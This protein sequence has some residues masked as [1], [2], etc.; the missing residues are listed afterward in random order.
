MQELRFRNLAWEKAEHRRYV[1]DSI[2]V[3]NTNTQFEVAYH[4]GSKKH[5]IEIFTTKPHDATRGKTL[6][7]QSLTECAVWIERIY[8]VKTTGIIPD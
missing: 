5:S 1:S 4:H 3:E 7:F 6:F 2:K 8:R